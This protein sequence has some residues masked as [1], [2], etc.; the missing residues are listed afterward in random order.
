MKGSGDIAEKLTGNKSSLYVVG[1]ILASRVHRAMFIA[2]AAISQPVELEHARTIR[3]H[4]TRSG[5]L[6]WWRQMASGNFNYIYEAMAKLHD[7]SLLLKMGMH[8]D[9]SR[10]APFSF[11]DA[12]QQAIAQSVMAL[13]ASVLA[14]EIMYMCWFHMYLP[15]RFFALTSESSDEV[16][17]A[18]AFCKGAWDDLLAAEEF[19]GKQD[20]KV[21]DFLKSLLWPRSTW[22][23]EILIGLR[24]AGFDKPPPDIMDMLMDAAQGC[25]GSKDVEDCFN[26]LRTEANIETL[27]LWMHFTKEE[28]LST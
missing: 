19:A 9:S 21:S 8:P 22:A 10:T 7:P 17:S 23:R 12:D 13:T 4:K 2:I 16:A 15:G 6:Q 1:D 3:E 18:Q 28:N 25:T 27:T 11:T 24:E 26:Y 5:T 14:R 20:V